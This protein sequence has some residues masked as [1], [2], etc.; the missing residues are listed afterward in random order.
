MT[1]LPL[2]YSSSDLNA[3]NIKNYINLNSMLLFF[4]KVNPNPLKC[5][6]FD[7]FY[8]YTNRRKILNSAITKILI[9]FRNF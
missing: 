6:K 9:P 7:I 1:L 4:Y 5:V 8:L 3:A 2:L